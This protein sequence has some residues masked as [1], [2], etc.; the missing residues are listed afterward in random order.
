MGRLTKQGIDYFSLDVEWDDKTEMYLIENE[1]NGLA[2][3]VTIWQLIFK[4]EGYYIMDNNDLYLLIKKRIS[5]DIEVIKS[6]IDSAVKREIFDSELHKNY[7]ILTSKGVQ[8]RFFDAAKKKKEVRYNSNYL[9]INISVYENVK[10]SNGNLEKSDG[11]ATKEK[12]EEKEKVNNTEEKNDPVKIQ[13]AI[14]E[15]GEFYG[16]DEVKYWFGKRKFN[17]WFTGGQNPKRITSKNWRQDLK[18]WMMNPINGKRDGPKPF[19]STNQNKQSYNDYE[20]GRF[21]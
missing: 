21:V 7:G 2:V 14:D 11:N 9:L 13:T 15:F 8:K 3:L 20:D 6:C 17:D 19:K 4:N 12:E 10:D 5:L 1:A 18:V 16:N